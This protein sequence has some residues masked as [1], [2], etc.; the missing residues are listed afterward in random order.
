MVT[1][2]HSSHNTEDVFIRHVTGNLS[3]LLSWQEFD[4]VCEYIIQNADKGWYIYALDK[5][6]PVN[7]VTSAELDHFITSLNKTVHQQYNREH[8]GIAFVDTLSEPTFFKI[9]NPKL[10][11]SICNIYGASPIHGWI[12][13]QQKPM[14][15][16]SYI[17]ENSQ[18]DAPR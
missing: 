6:P 13:S 17:S 15:L 3:G 4:A 11:K 8:C 10:L 14:D 16:H 1:Q 12:I 9:F 18:H 5:Q 7:T 2:N